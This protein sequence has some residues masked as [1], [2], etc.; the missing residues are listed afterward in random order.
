MLDQGFFDC[1]PFPLSEAA[2]CN[3]GVVDITTDAIDVDGDCECEDLGPERGLSDLLLG[4]LVGPGAPKAVRLSRR[5]VC[6][7]SGSTNSDRGG[8]VGGG[9][10]EDR[11]CWRLYPDSR[12]GG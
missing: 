2:D 12:L 8:G 7:F 3:V 9:K 6:G 10:G 11:G 5:V 1:L 4:C